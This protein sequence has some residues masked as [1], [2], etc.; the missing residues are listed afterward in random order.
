MGQEFKPPVASVYG[1]E[2]NRF[3]DSFSH[4]PNHR[5]IDSV[6]APY[7]KRRPNP[8]HNINAAAPENRIYRI[9]EPSYL[10]ATTATAEQYKI[11]TNTSRKFFRPTLSD[12]EVFFVLLNGGNFMMLVL[13]YFAGSIPNTGDKP[14]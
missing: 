5:K 8:D 2:K 12:T 13:D 9:A 4:N 14:A 10:V 1:R 3:T 11:T 6:V 7:P